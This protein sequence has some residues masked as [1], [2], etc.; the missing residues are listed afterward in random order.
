MES[1]RLV[2]RLAGGKED[3]QK[4][5]LAGR[6]GSGRFRV[7]GFGFRVELDRIWSRDGGKGKRGRRLARWYRA[8]NKNF[9]LPYSAG[10]A[11]M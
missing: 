7:G 6:G 10:V 1:I 11:C 8:R 9:R 5:E 3:G 2:G 4:F